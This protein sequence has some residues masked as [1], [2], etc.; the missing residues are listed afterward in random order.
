[1][2]I[3]VELIVVTAEMFSS[4][5]KKSRF[6]LT[7]VAAS[8]ATYLANNSTACADIKPK[9]KKVVVIGGGSG[10]IGVSAM[11][12]NE[13]FD[14]VSVIEPSDK[15]YYQPIWSLV[16]CNASSNTKSVRPMKDIFP[17]SAKWIQQSAAKIDPEN[18]TVVLADGT[19]V[20]YDFLV[21][22][23]GIESHWDG[24]PGLKEALDDENSGVVSIYD[25]N[26]VQKCW[27]N[28]E[29]FKGGRALFMMP[30][31]PIKC[32]GAPQKIMWLFE[33]RMRD[34]NLRDKTSVE[35][36]VPGGAMFGVKKYSDMLTVLQKERNV[37]PQ[38]KQVLTSVDGKNKK[39][40]F[41][42][43]DTGVETVEAYDL[44]H[45]VPPMGPPAVVKS[46]P[47]AAP[48]GFMDVNQ[49]TL[50]SPKYPNVFGLGDCTTTPNSK[51]AAAITKQAP[52]LV[53]NLTQVA[54]GKEPN[55]KYNG[56]ASCPLIVGKDR[57][58]LAEFGYGGKIME[59]FSS[60]TGKFPYSMFGQEGSIQQ[61]AFFTL[62]ET[63][64]P[65]VYWNLWT[66]GKWFGTSGPFKP[67]VLEEDSK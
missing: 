37:I 1:L 55:A 6:I 4:H 8:S 26:Y 54:E 50:Q 35:W 13:G 30:N 60:E 18:N 42:N 14:N 47:L 41:K 62:K 9:S 61:R 11:L 56:Y 39:A 31:T 66:K 12:G 36:W 22:S 44:L 51:T 38:F 10:G 16:G 52:I 24:I 34:I 3:F 53:H 29:A 67:N 17:K 57:V 15:H 5:L 48:T 21:V 32:P 63:I 43:V 23:A 27:K 7:A 65:Y 19:K 40:T 59:T 20:E 25:Y 49:H 64:F 45:A 28:I 46:S 58:I 33:E 2:T